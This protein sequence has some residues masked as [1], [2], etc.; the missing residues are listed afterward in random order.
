MQSVTALAL[1][2][3][4]NNYCSVKPCKNGGTCH[5]VN[6]KY[7]CVC[8][9][10]Y[11]GDTCGEDPCT[12][13]RC[14]NGGTCHVSGHIFRCVCKAPYQGVTCEEKTNEISSE[15]ATISVIDTSSIV[16]TTSIAEGKRQVTSFTDRTFNEIFDNFQLTSIETMDTIFDLDV[17]NEELNSTSDVNAT[18]ITID[19][20]DIT[21]NNTVEPGNNHKC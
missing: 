8:K 4:A 21:F 19:S 3:I 7:K 12:G 1:A 11:F 5:N 20:M 16:P 14:K 13:D 15:E 2:G 17:A 9:H 18:I 6:E 10:P